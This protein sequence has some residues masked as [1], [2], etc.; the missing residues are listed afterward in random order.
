[1]SNANEPA[2]PISMGPVSDGD[3]IP[4]L[5]KRELFAAMAMQGMLS[6]GYDKYMRGYAGWRE[7][8]GLEAFRFAD[9]L[10]AALATPSEEK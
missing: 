9:A 7:E 6:G 2:F 4:G 10:L 3:Y 8:F 5:T 1:M